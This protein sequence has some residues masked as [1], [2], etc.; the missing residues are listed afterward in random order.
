[1]KV[2]RRA[3]EAEWQQEMREGE[4]HGEKSNY[5]AAS[6]CDEGGWQAGRAAARDSAAPASP[7][8]GPP[9]HATAADWQPQPAPGRCTL[10][11]CLQCKCASAF[12]RVCARACAWEPGRGACLGC[13]DYFLCVLFFIQVDTYSIIRKNINKYIHF[14]CFLLVLSWVSLETG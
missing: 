8:L 7:S 10:S 2:K 14:W 5:L 1:M 12:S 11:C 6:G 13:K 3:T 4:R 9:P